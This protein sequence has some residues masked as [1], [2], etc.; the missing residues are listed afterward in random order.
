MKALVTGAGGAV[1][2]VLCRALVE[3]GDEVRGLVHHAPCEVR[4]VEVVRGDITAPE[5]LVGIEEGVDCVFHLAARVNYWGGKALF[6]RVTVEGTANLLE[7]CVGKVGRFVYVSSIAVY[8][9]GRHLR[10]FTEDSPL[11]KTGLP[12][13]DA[14]IDAE[15]IVGAYT[16]DTE[17]DYTIVR[18][19]VV[20]GP[21]AACVCDLVDVLQ[22]IPVPLIDG[23]RNSTSFVYV[24][25]LVD[26]IILAG[27]RDQARNRSYNF[28]DDYDVCWRDYITDV[29]RMVGRRPSVRVPTRVA[30]WIGSLIEAL[31]LPFSAARPPITRLA[32]AGVGFDNDVDTTRARQEL[33]WS[34]RVGYPQAM[35]EVE[36]WVHEYVAGG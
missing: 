21:S 22:R 16:F 33:G 11:V 26:G 3:R 5:T 8:G 14:K 35:S 36:A 13:A 25:N 2:R 15:R 32:V 34:T 9:M 18:P 6:Q 31:Y 29:G 20:L 12:Y 19:A 27:T 30:W 7:R 23:G 4:G 10:G 28:R 1:G 24:D 17:T